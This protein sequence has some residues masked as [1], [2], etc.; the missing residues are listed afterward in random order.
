MRRIFEV[1]DVVSYFDDKTGRQRRA[2]IMVI[3]HSGSDASLGVDLL[4]EDGQVRFERMQDIARE[5]PEQL[6]KL[7]GPDLRIRP[8]KAR[9]WFEAAL[10]RKAASGDPR[11]ACHEWQAAGAVTGLS[12]PL[13]RID[14]FSDDHC[15]AS[16]WLAH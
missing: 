8:E 10:A 16:W 4:C 7:R 6:N 12:P 1:G 5:N 13:P 2:Q 14:R 11:W 9:R 3:R 15:K